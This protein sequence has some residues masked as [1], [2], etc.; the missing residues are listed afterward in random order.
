MILELWMVGVVIAVLLFIR[1][2]VGLAF[3]GPSLWYALADGRSQRVLAE[4]G[5]RRPEQLPAAGRP[6]VHP[7]RRH[8]QPARH[9][10]PALRVLPG[11]AR[12]GAGQP[13]LRQRRLRRRLLLDERVGAGRRGRAGQ[14]ADPADGQGRLPVRVRRRAD[15]VVVADQ[16]GD[17]AEHPGRHLRRDGDGVHRCA[18]RRVGHSRPSSW[19]S[20]S[21]S[22]SSSGRRAGR[23]SRRCRSTG[24][25]SSRPRSASSARCS[26]R[27]SCSA[28]SCPASS[29]RPRRP[30]SPWLY[31]LVLGVHLPHGEAAGAAAGA[32]GDGGHHRR[33][34]AHPRCGGAAGPDPD[35]GPRLARRRRVPDV[36]CRTT[37][38]SS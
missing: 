16:P 31:M 26:P 19:R 29:P 37:R 6:A 3:I 23:S 28:A 11:R 25:G 20:G 2:P 10:R 24:S 34:H 33:H 32:A 27:S 5:L 7:R 21:A 12:P 4:D 9:R 1:V 13:G 35:P 38:G 14:D 8:G 17:A 18:V 36:G 22:T 15:R 30:P